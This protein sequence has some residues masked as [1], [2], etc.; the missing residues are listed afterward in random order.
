M[1]SV[2]LTGACPGFWKEGSSPRR[3]L[4]FRK[5]EAQIASK[6]NLPAK[7]DYKYYEKSHLRKKGGLQVRRYTS[8]INR[9]KLKR[10]TKFVT[11]YEG[12]KIVKATQ[13]ET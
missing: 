7:I 6:N 4:P 2:K 1:F 5:R 11:Q 12:S 8:P 10:L 9:D 3:V 13:Q